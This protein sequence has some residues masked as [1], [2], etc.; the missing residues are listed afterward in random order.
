MRVPLNIPRSTTRSRPASP[1]C[2]ASL[3]PFCVVGRVPKV[4]PP[5]GRVLADDAVIL[6]SDRPAVGP[7]E[8][9]GGGL[10]PVRRL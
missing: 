10:R 4:S 9:A 6:A 8:S 2:R 3:I 7:P 5:L 1:H